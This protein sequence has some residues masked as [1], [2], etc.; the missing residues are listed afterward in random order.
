LVTTRYDTA[1]LKNIQWL[2]IQKVNQRKQ[3]L[4]SKHEIYPNNNGLFTRAYQCYRRATLSYPFLQYNYKSVKSSLYGRLGNYLGFTGYYNPF[5][6]EAQLNTTIPRFLLP[7]TT[8]HEIAHQL[9]YAK[10]DEANFVGYLSAISSTDTL[11]HYSAYFDLFLYANKE[12][13]YLDSAYAKESYKQLIPEVQNDIKEFREF[14]L[15]HRNPVEPYITWLYS[16]YLKA[17]QQPE[18][19][20]T[21]NEVIAN[22]I[23]FYKKSGKI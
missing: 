1:E 15:E 16:K 17:N 20:R 12:L 22:L 5:S 7:Y 3:T 9:G 14:L 8:C 23:A 6:G 10:E 13:Y 19:M 4:V 21:Y 11:F 18:G 2:L